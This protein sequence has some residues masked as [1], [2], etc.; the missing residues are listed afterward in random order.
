MAGAVK[1]RGPAQIHALDNDVILLRQ[2]DFKRL[3][4]KIVD[5]LRRTDLR[6]GEKEGDMP[7]FLDGY[8]SVEQPRDMPMSEALLKAT[9][10]YA[11]ARTDTGE[12]LAEFERDQFARASKIQEKSQS[13]LAVQIL[14]E[15]EEGE[16]E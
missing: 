6:P 13:E 14:L 16:A 8:V 9:I 11:L 1:H 7:W 15:D 5:M 4:P 10:G 3:G 12:I 2:V